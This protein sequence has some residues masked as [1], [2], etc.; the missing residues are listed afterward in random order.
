LNDLTFFHIFHLISHFNLPF[1]YY[2]Y[3]TTIQLTFL[4]YFS[5]LFTIFS[6][7]F[8]IFSLFNLHFFHM[9]HIFVS[10]FL[11]I[12]S[13]IRGKWRHVRGKQVTLHFKRCGLKKYGKMKCL[14]TSCT[15]K[16]S[17]V[18]IY[19]REI[20]WY[21]WPIAAHQPVIFYGW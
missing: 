4:P 17:N 5:Y 12:L 16:T 11:M 19:I 1:P 8:P 9:F 13:M 3:L 6:P 14:M 10:L 18:A 15:R 20:Y 21:I 2:P 7:I